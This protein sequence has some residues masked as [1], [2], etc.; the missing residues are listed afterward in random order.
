MEGEVR[1]EM[2]GDDFRV[3]LMIEEDGEKEE[4]REFWRIAEIGRAHV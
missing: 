3:L 4:T 2:G 1:G